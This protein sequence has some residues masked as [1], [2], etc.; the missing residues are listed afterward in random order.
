VKSGEV[1]HLVGQMRGWRDQEQ[2]N[3]YEGKTN[4]N[5]AKVRKLR[6]K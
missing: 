4:I 2:K 3:K 1:L 6:R 5:A